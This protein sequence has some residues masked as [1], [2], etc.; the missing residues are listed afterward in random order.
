[1][2]DSLHI[3]TRLRALERRVEATIS[4]GDSPAVFPTLFAV[5]E[6]LPLIADVLTRAETLRDAVRRD[7]NASQEVQA[8]KPP[9]DAA[10]RKLEEALDV[11]Q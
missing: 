7:E 8:A 1:M 11:G 2:T 3:G 10:L 9:F 4:G 5:S 6:A